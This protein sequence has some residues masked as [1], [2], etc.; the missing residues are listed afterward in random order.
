MTSF[1]KRMIWAAVIA[2]IL[3]VGAAGVYAFS[4][5]KYEKVKVSGGVVSIPVSKVSDGK[6]HFYRFDDGGKEINFIV[7]KAADGGIRTAFDACDSCFRE[8][9]GYEQSG[10]KLVCQ[11]CR[12]QFAIRSI[13]PHAVGGC[14][15]SYL[16]NQVK[17]SSVTITAADLKAGAR[18]F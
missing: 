5:G 15:P 13:G 14:N 17:G 18:F 10:D 8:K 3:L 4:F 11:N 7:A 16:P 6:A 2:G 9:K 1:S 12:R